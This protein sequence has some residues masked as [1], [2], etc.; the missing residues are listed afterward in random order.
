MSEE[1]PTRLYFYRNNRDM[2]ALDK[3]DTVTHIQAIATIAILAVNTILTIGLF[4]A[5][6]GY[7]HASK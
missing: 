2:P 1:L 6:L 4:G 5:I 3:R 7:L